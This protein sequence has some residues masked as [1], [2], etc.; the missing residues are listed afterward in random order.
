MNIERLAVVMMMRFSLLIA[1]YGAWLLFQSAAAN[2]IRDSMV[3]RS[4]IGI[5][6]GPLGSAVSEITTAGLCV[7]ICQ[8]HR[9]S[10][11]IV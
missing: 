11:R 6:F 5:P 1:A 2:R 3:R 8:T 7:Q 10:L 4:F 9:N